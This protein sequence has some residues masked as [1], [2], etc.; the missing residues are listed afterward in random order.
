MAFTSSKIFAYHGATGAT[1]A[2]G[3]NGDTSISG[4]PVDNQVAIW[5]DAST[6]EGTNS[7][8]F[9]STGLD[10][11]GNQLVLGS[12][13]GAATRTDGTAKAASI[14]GYHDTNAEEPLQGMFLWSD[15]TVGHVYIG[16][17]S[18]LTNAATDIKFYTAANHTTTSGT[19]RMIID[20]DGNVGIGPVGSPD[21]TLHLYDASPVIKLED[22][23]PDGVYAQIDGAGGDLILGANYGNEAGVDGTIKL[24]VDNVI[25][26][27]IDGTGLGVGG[28]TPPSSELHVTGTSSI[29]FRVETT[30]ALNYILIE[31]SGG[32]DNYIETNAGSIALNAD[33]S[34]SSGYVYLKTN[35]DIALTVDSLQN[36]GIGGDNPD[37]PL[38]VRVDQN[39][40]T[41][42]RVI[43][44]NS[45]AA[46]LARHIIES[47]NN[48]FQISV[49]SPTHSTFAD[50]VIMNMTGADTLKFSSG[51]SPLMTILDSGNVGIGASPATRRR[52]LR[53]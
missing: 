39:S 35:D 9:D 21:T 53:G 8:V 49:H 33:S 34:G 31:N 15:A 42:S 40:A 10:I 23:S 51:G 25:K 3:A 43:N 32:Q 4:T 20:K 17:G 6:I 18:S 41:I 29:P 5:T 7:L 14:E 47:N 13:N 1:G 19:E 52:L 45:H 48:N 24:S 2:D 37:H 11:S 36:V 38:D 12:D 26:A 46:A 50:E 28:S 16:G 27:T 30:N 22:S 44:G